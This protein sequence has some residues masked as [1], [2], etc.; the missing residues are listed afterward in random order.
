MSANIDISSQ[1]IYSAQL[2]SDSPTQ[3]W[4]RYDNIAFVQYEC[5]KAKQSDCVNCLLQHTE[6]F[7]AYNDES[8]TEGYV[9][10]HQTSS[11]ILKSCVGKD[12]LSLKYD[13]R[14]T[15]LER[16]VGLRQLTGDDISST[17][18]QFQK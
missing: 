8:T 9:W 3:I 13:T 16:P 5:E 1:A 17:K 4:S 15:Q 2:Q 6:V 7:F 11:L 14:R 10:M 18:A 12:C